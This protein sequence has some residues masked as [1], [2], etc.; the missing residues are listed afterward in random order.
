MSPRRARLQREWL[1]LEIQRYRR[2]LEEAGEAP[3][4]LGE[5]IRQRQGKG[6][7][8][9][10][11]LQ[12]HLERHLGGPLPKIVIHADEEADA[13]AGALGAEAFTSGPDVFF[14][15][16]AYDPESEAGQ[17]LIAH[18][19]VHVLQQAR[20]P[21]DGTPTGGGVKLSSP[22]DPY[23]QEA[24][25]KARTLPKLDRRAAAPQPREPW[26]RARERWQ[27][28]TQ[29]LIREYR[30][31]QDG[32]AIASELRRLQPDD[33]SAVERAL[34]TF[35]SRGEWRSLQKALEAPTPAASPA[36]SVPCDKG[37]E[38]APVE[39]LEPR[40][41]TPRIEP[42]VATPRIEPPNATPRLEPTVAQ[43]FAN[44]EVAVQRN[45]LT[46]GLKKVG[47]AA[48]NAVGA[49]FD[50]VKD[51]IAD[52]A[53]NLPGY[54]ELTQ[55]LG[56][57]PISGKNVQVQP[58]AFL[59]KLLGLPVVPPFARNVLE[60]LQ[61]AGEAVSRGWNWF[62]GELGKL[63]LG[64][65]FKNIVDGLRSLGPSD[66]LSPVR[67]FNEKVKAPVM[68][69]INRF[70]GLAKNSVLKLGE[71]VLDALAKNPTAKRVVEGVK[72]AG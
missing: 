48:G 25:S 29:R 15:K 18:E 26:S 22:S 42:R 19:A 65:A 47:N 54:K 21:V 41:A 53:A 67:A 28:T 60:G 11:A 24:E 27:D 64:P 31:R 70:L 49:G 45:W 1:H 51:K 58:G 34:R 8:L 43:R 46:D 39:P 68:A 4:D 7:P 6:S 71:F 3:P 10:A 62:K 57:D 56:H 14:R 66:L 40:V 33:R 37:P 35:L 69:A 59:N 61:K 17:R 12:A 55:A 9:P 5:R 63:N 36:A 13:L 38:T 16:G 2:R 32:P 52:L 72:G 20:G 50:L 44:R 30:A 23:E